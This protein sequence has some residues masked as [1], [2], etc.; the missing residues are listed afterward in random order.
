MKNRQLSK[1]LKKLDAFPESP[2]D[3]E[4]WEQFLTEVEEAYIA[5]DQER[6]ELEQSLADTSQEMQDVYE[7]LK[8]TS[9][10]R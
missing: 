5:A 4:T 3:L 1:Q 6:G 10:A 9:E 7:D 8:H 2:P